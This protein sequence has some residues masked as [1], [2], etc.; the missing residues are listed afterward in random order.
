[1]NDTITIRGIVAT[2]PRHIVTNAGLAITSFRLASPSRRWD[3]ASSSW[4]NGDTNWF[5]ITAFRSLASNLDGSLAKGDRV[6]VIGRLR[7]RTWERD[8]RT[9]FAVEID[10]DSIGHDLA[11]GKSTWRKTLRNVV[12]E[13]AA[14]GESPSPEERAAAPD[15]DHETEPD[16]DAVEREVVPTARVS[17][18]D[19]E[20]GATGSVR[21]DSGGG[22]EQL[23]PAG[24]EANASAW[25]EDVKPVF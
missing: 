13:T 12:D 3:R 4:V 22:T 23:A 18:G 16:A 25:S 19:S 6:I 8:D 24:A 15:S 1:M 7:V 5:T 14:P 11:W 17:A 2:E 10:A 21:V 9:G 20:T